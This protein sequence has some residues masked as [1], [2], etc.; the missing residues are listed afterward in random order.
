MIA[1]RFLD[2]V[3][4]NPHFNLLKTRSKITPKW[5]NH[6]RLTLAEDINKCQQLLVDHKIAKN[7]RVAFR[8]NNSYD[9]VT[10]NLATNGLGAIWVPMYSNQSSDYSRYILKDCDAKLLISDEE[11]KV[12]N[13]TIP[14]EYYKNITPNNKGVECT[15]SEN[16]IFDPAVLIYTSGTTGDPKG[17]TLSNMNILANI[18]DMHKRFETMDTHL[19]SLNILPWA[20][21]YGMTCELY[22]NMLNDNQIAICSSRENFLKECREVSPE[23]LYLVPKVMELVKNKTE[24]IARVPV[25]GKLIMPTLLKK[26]FGGNLQ[27]IFMGGAKLH[28]DTM[29]FF[30]TNQI[31]ICEGYGCSE[32]SPMISVNHMESPRNT[33]SVGK[34]LA[35]VEVDIINSEICVSGPNVMK[36]YWNKPDETA[37]VILEKDGRRLYKTGD[38]GY[39]K[40]GYIFFSGRISENYKMLNGKFVNVNKVETSIKKYLNCNFIIYGENM[41]YNILYTD[42]EVTESMLENINSDLES[43]LRI[44]KVVVI[45]FTPYLT[46]KMSIKRKQVIS[47]NFNS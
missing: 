45:D 1:R 39:V 24:K 17:V 34:I 20:H 37:K 13:E 8:G 7:D 23:L 32:T 27:N 22:Y 16:D 31:N 26:L 6:S 28:S 10:W 40:D 30:E 19:T 14:I 21:I 38:A 35:S 12:N 42:E 18:S 47:S 9:W 44:K 36:G 2:T 15:Y 41:D 25:L 46:P 5:Y 11:I 33:A 4:K 3:N 29:H 43:Y